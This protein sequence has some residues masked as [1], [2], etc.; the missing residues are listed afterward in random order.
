MASTAPT[1]RRLRLQKLRL[2]KLRLQKLRLRKPGRIYFS[3]IRNGVVGWWDGADD[4][5]G[6]RARQ[7]IQSRMEESIWAGMGVIRAR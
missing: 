6:F 1:K 5:A 3:M 2:Q 4:R 7:S